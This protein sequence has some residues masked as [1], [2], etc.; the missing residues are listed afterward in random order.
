ME[1]AQ[2]YSEQVKQDWGQFSEAFD[3]G[4]FKVPKGDLW[5]ERSQDYRAD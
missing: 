2:T 5:A 4:I 1:Y 3:Q